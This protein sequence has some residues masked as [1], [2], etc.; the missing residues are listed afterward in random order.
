MDFVKQY[1]LQCIT[2]ASSNLRL[3]NQRIEIIAMLKEVI[4]K[5]D[6]IQQDL[7]R[8]KKITELSKLAIKLNE[9]YSAVN[10]TSVDFLKITDKFKEHSFNLIKDLSS[11]LDSVNPYHF[12]ETI[13]S[14]TESKIKPYEISSNKDE[15]KKLVSLIDSEKISSSKNKLDIADSSEDGSKASGS[16]SFSFAEEIKPSSPVQNLEFEHEKAIFF[17]D[18]ESSILTPIKRIDSL[19][20][21]FIDDSSTSEEI[22]YCIN[23]AKLNHELSVQNGFDILAKMHYIISEGLLY[24]KAKK[25][26]PS[27]EVIESLRACLIVIAAVVKSKEVD[28]KNYLNL[29]EEFGKFLAKIQTEE[30]R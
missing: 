18:F 2:V 14:L 15:K 5:S 1:I 23:A 24:L 16:Q 27:R 28:I 20:N 9:I 21:T 7:N 13:D 25:L 22:D 4:L 10:E 29:A 12:R 26:S 3:N 8:M 17:N 19:L 11:M 6:D 30:T